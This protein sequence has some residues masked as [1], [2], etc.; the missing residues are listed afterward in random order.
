MKGIFNPYLLRPFDN[1]LISKLV[2][3][4][5]TCEYTTDY[6]NKGECVH[7]KRNCKLWTFGCEPG[8][9]AFQIECAEVQVCGFK[10]LS[11]AWKLTKNTVLKLQTVA[12]LGCSV[13]S[14]LVYLA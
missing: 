14:L 5:R 8:V 1:K 6:I 10:V 11:I 9:K 12:R 4:F 13:S 3:C 7:V 2:P